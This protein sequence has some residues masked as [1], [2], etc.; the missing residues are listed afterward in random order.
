[1]DI[2]FFLLERTKFIAFFYKT[3]STPFSQIM[4]DIVNQ[5]PPYVPP[6]SE[7]AEP[8]FLT[9]WL[10]AKYGLDTCGHHAISM[11]SSSLQLFLKAWVDRLDR[12][13]GMTFEVNFKKNGWLNG[14]LQIFK[15]LELDMDD[16]P[17]NL[18][19][20]EQ[21]PLVRNRIQHPEHLTSIYIEHSDNDLT[22][23]SR[24]YFIQE[25]EFDSVSDQENNSWLL[26]PV[27]S[28][29]H[30]KIMEAVNNVELLGSWLENQYRKARN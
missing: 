13:Q 20:I 2:E 21:L 10:D 24:P 11:L 26:P 18:K 29:S 16:C 4:N 22:K 8:P 12:F 5:I 28:P 3:A 9:E 19:I 6:Y 27:I 25:S 1:M 30:E 14:Y 7:D 23:L 15:E 17:A